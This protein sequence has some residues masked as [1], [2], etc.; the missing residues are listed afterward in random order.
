FTDAGDTEDIALAEPVVDVA[1]TL[2]GRGY[3]MA[4]S[5]GGVFSFGDATFFGSMGGIPLNQPIVAM[6]A[7][8]GGEGYYLVAS[9]GGVF[10]FGDATFFGSTGDLTLNSPIVDIQPT[11]TGLGYWMVAADGGIFAFGDAGF[12]GS[13]GGTTNPA[14]IVGMAVTASGNGYWLV[15][16]LGN[17]SNF[18]DAADPTDPV[19]QGI[20]L[21][22]PIVSMAPANNGQGAW[23]FTAEGAAY[24]LAG[25]F[26]AADAGLTAAAAGDPFVG[27]DT[28]PDPF[29]LTVLHNNDGES[30]LSPDDGIGGVAFFASTV[31][32]L[33]N[34]VEPGDNGSIL[35]NSGDNFLASAALTASFELADAT[36]G[37]PWYDSVALDRID[38][39]AFALGNHEF[40]FGPDRL[41]EFIEGFEGG[42]ERFLSANL[43]FSGEAGLQ[44]LVD[45]GTIAPSTIVT[46]QGR[47]IGV[48]GATTPELASISSPRNVVIDPMVAAAIQTEVDTMTGN[49]VEIIIVI[50]HL[51]DVDSDIALAA[52]LTGVDVVIAGGGDEILANEGDELAP[53]DEAER[54]YPILGE[55]ADGNV[56]P[57]VTTAGDYKYVGQLILDFDD[58]GNLL[59]VVGESGPVL[60]QASATADSGIQSDVV[61]PVEAFE[62]GL[63]TTVLASSE[64]EL[65]SDRGGPFGTTP[66]KRVQE[67]NL[68]N[69]IADALLFEGQRIAA[70]NGADVPQ[71]A[72]QNGGGIREDDF[73]DGATTPFDITTLDTFNLLPFANFVTIIEDLSGAELE[74]ILEAAYSELP[75]ANGGFAQVAGMVV[76][77]E[78]DPAQAPD[79]GSANPSVDVTDITLDGGTQILVANVDQGVT[80]DVATNSF[81]AGGGDGYPIPDMASLVNL[82]SS[83]RDALEN[84]LT[85]PTGLN[86]LIDDAVYPVVGVGELGTGGA[87]RILI[88]NTP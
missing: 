73:S 34:G 65:E 83:Y 10:A 70:A 57:V 2:T 42:D 45:A 38:Y 29:T 61:A 68:G 84:F 52:E 72:I 5:D 78:F 67:T 71:V 63:A 53:G 56:V 80:V 18:G 19:E 30:S 9:D 87:T 44:A 39:D 27:V 7:S 54:P 86:G 88:D 59:G 60:V 74:A 32:A 24:G 4:A 21:S 3:W 17:V 79:D 55:D 82:P 51:Q 23:L 6:A 31:E 22:T 33:R 16:E 69:V 46:V 35:L 37:T 41:Q 50:S 15:D 25:A 85:D 66:G 1:S 28:V 11:P 77:V 36:P 48:V 8:A 76:E 40:D 58:D 49:G 81:S 43:D 64:V 12:F 62:A 75:G 47:Q 13:D 20:V 26:I 14:P